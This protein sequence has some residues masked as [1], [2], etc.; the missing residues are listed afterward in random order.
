LN[1]ININGQ[2][3]E[4]PAPGVTG[5][6]NAA[7]RYGYGL[8][9][10]MLVQKGRIRLWSYHCNRLYAGVQQLRLELPSAGRVEQEVLALAEKNESSALCRVRLQVFG[11]QGMYGLD[12]KAGY[13][14][15]CFPVNDAGIPVEGGR[16]VAGIAAG[17][18]KSIDAF[19]NL[20]TCSALIYAMALQDAKENNW[21]D[22]LICNVH[23]NVIESSIANIFWIKANE[24]YTPPL[25][26]GCVAGVMRQYIVDTLAV[27]EQPLT[28]TALGEADEVFLTNAI[29]IRSVKQVGSRVYQTPATHALLSGLLL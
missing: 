29:R 11:G 20:K 27:K 24:L 17:V 10:T 18:K 6:D 5:Y 2:I 23:G 8:F 9:E 21:Q 22:A 19:S 4:A 26:E 28:V 14:I 16:I 15:E 25:S 7:F 3:M 12:G 13:I 1:H